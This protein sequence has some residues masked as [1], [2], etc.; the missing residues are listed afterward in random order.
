MRREVPKLARAAT[1]S[2]NLEWAVETSARRSSMVAISGIGE[3]ANSI[4]A[5]GLTPRSQSTKTQ[6][7]DGDVV[8]RKVDRL[9]RLRVEHATGHPG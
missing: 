7:V 2:T 3:T 6:H 8:N 9:V 1:R 5:R 4:R